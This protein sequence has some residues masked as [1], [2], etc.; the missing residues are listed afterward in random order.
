[1]VEPVDP[2]HALQP[3]ND[4][5]RL[6]FRNLY[7]S[8]IRLDC[9]GE[10]RP[11]LAES[12][13]RESDAGVWSLM[14]R[15]GARWSS[16]APVTAADVARDLTAAR[17]RS[18]YPGIDSAQPLGPRQLRL[19]LPSTENS[20]IDVLADPTLAIPDSGWTAASREIRIPAHDGLPEVELLLFPGEDPR[21]VLDRGVD[22]M[23]TRERRLM[24]YAA[25]RPELESV[26][27]PWTRSYVLV[28]PP[29]A[30][31]LQL[32]ASEPERRSLARDAVPADA[33]P[34]EPI[35]WWPRNACSGQPPDSAGPSR[36]PRIAYVRG[37][38]VARTLAE[39]AVAVA[40]PGERLKTLALEPEEF[41]A[42]LSRGAER[43]YVVA[44]PRQSLTPCADATQL[45]T[46]WSRQPLV[47]TRAHAILR[48]SAPALT[49][50]WDGVVRPAGR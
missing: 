7:R 20:R 4:S 50:D 39:R 17:S 37:D 30:P 38:E 43:A 46:G 40:E 32:A 11:E 23:I 47:D 22:L 36:A 15:D 9:R 34:A 26:P 21:D 45:P 3:R 18:P 35:A 1:M 5:E 48:K 31:L 2:D 25:G 24:E 16:G 8:L 49:V 29:G 44:L 6:L 13:V 14:T 42:S 33:R 27:L 10:A 19:F 28:A 12:W 41:R